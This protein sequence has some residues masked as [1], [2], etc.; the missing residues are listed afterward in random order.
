MPD[1]DQRYTVDDSTGQVESCEVFDIDGI[2][3]SPDTKLIATPD[4][5]GTVEFWWLDGVC[6]DRSLRVTRAGQAFAAA[7]IEVREAVPQTVQP[8]PAVGVLRGAR[9][10]I[11]DSGRQ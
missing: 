10:Q 11:A 4:A 1:Y 7:I 3:H 5:N 6:G 8:C 9:M 2:W